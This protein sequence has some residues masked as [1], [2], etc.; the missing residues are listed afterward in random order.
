MSDQ[1]DIGGGI[2]CA[3][4][5]I[6]GGLMLGLMFSGDSG[7][8]FDGHDR[9]MAVNKCRGAENTF[10][11]RLACTQAVYGRSHPLEEAD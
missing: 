10:E 8:D 3:G 9:A 2:A 5:F 1:S 7:P 4:I 6:G 11:A